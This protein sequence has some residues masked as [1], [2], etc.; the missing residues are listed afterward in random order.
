MLF[1]LQDKTMDLD[2]QILEVKSI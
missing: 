2:F 1:S